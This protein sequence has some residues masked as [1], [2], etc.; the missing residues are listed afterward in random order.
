VAGPFATLYL[1]YTLFSIT[2][3]SYGFGKG[4]VTVLKWTM[5]EN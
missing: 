5:R 4:A 2:L 1:V 3:T